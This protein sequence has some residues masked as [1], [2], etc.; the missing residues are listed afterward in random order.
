MT[1]PYVKISVERIEKLLA[2]EP[3]YVNVSDIIADI[4]HYCEITKTPFQEVL[5]R[6]FAYHAADIGVVH[7]EPQS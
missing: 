7:G 1:N 2:S 5:E 4:L 6:G 3:N